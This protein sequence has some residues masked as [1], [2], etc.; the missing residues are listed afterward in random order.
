M[1]L[2]SSDEYLDPVL[3]MKKSLMENFIFSTVLI[4]L[5]SSDT[6]LDETGLR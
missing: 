5:S 6:S 2:Y 4:M 3:K 1:V